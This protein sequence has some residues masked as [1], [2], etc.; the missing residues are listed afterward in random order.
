MAMVSA[1]RPVVYLTA[2]TT[3]VGKL[4]FFANEMVVGL[5]VRLYLAT[6]FSIVDPCRPATAATS[7]PKGMDGTLLE[8]VHLHPGMPCG[9]YEPG[10]REK[11]HFGSG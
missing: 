10:R 3:R 11:I 7:R 6:L 9:R 8:A 4:I 5:R 2:I 1:S